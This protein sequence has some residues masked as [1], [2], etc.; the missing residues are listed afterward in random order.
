MKYN[1][2]QKRFDIGLGL[3]FQIVEHNGKLRV[4]SNVPEL[5]KVLDETTILGALI[6][7]NILLRENPI[8]INTGRVYFEEFIKENNIKELL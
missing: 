3:Y 8:F 6:Y 2:T 5:N 4:M 1:K 7:T